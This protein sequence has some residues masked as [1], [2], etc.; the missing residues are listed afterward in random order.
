MGADP[1]DAEFDGYYIEGGEEGDKACFTDGVELD[2]VP[3][4]KLYEPVAAED[5]TD[6]ADDAGRLALQRQPLV[7]FVPVVLG[8]LSHRGG[9][10]GGPRQPALTAGPPRLPITSFGSI[11]TTNAG[12]RRNGQVGDGGA[13]NAFHTFTAEGPGG[14]APILIVSD[15][16][17]PW[18][19][20][21]AA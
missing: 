6:L 16:V 18:Q 20:D 13:S 15:A 2:Q 12:P 3:V 7:E 19:F 5:G 10:T 17:P 11:K 21:A 9:E 8:R 14:T 4:I 1:H